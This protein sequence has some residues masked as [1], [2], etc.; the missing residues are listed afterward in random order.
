MPKGIFVRTP[1]SVAVRFWPKVEKTTTCWLWKASI[2]TRGYGK[3][4]RTGRGQGWEH[5][6]RVSWQL[7]YGA[8]PEG[9]LVLHRCDVRHC[10]RPDHLFLGTFKDNT[11]DM[12]AKGRSGT[13]GETHHYAKLTPE[14]VRWLRFNR[15]VPPTVA[16]R[17]FNVSRAT[18]RDARSG[19]LWKHV[20]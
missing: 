7:H 18:I 1:K 5:A 3:F 2:G 11:A 15:N 10:V 17:Y 6:H 13:I 20:Q 8:V 19:K 9:Q 12:F 16:A 4:G 14:K